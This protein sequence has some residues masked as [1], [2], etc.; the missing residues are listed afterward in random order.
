MHCK[1]C[2]KEMADNALFCKYCGCKVS[3]SLKVTLEPQEQNNVI[4]TDIAGIT[5]G[6]VSNASTISGEVKF[7]AERGH[8]FAAERVNHLHD[9]LMGKDALLVGDDNI[10]NGAD[11]MVNGTAIQSKYCS[12]GSKCIQE[13]FEDGKFRYLNPNGKPMQIEV[14]SDKY[15]DAV[16]AMQDRIRKGE[17]PGVRDPGDAKKYVKKGFLTYEQAKNV[18]RFGTIESIT[19]DAVNGAI[20]GT[21][22]FGITAAITFAVSIWN[23]DDF[24]TAL[25]NALISGLKVGGI[26]FATAV[27]A[28]QMTKAGAYSLV[29]GASGKIVQMIGPKGAALLVNA[30]RSG[31]NIYGAAA[32]KSAQKLLG[33]NIITA[34]VSIV[35]LSSIDIVNI[36]QGRISGAQFFKNLVN[37]TASVGGATAGWAGGAAAGAAVGSVFGPVGTTVGGCIGGVAGAFGVGAAANALSS[38]VTD[39]LIEDDPKKMIR[40]IESEFKEIAQNYMLNRDEADSIASSLSR[41]IDSSMLK[42]MYAS[43]SQYQF[44]R[45]LIEPKAEAIAKSRKHIKLPSQEQ[46]ANGLKKVLEHVEE[47]TMEES[48]E[49]H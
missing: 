21:T 1:G 27:L 37:T 5:Y 29:A 13:C 30:F 24:E 35:V 15:D 16:K 28:G 38:S 40:I 33:S 17:V 6:N 8:G 42:D 44:A 4:N 18:A 7:G 9:K 25:S 41:E 14:P 34:G 10:K 48:Y 32:M 47:Q 12:S 39:E 26:S 43:D 20:I 11:R 19:Y 36:F 2:G 49:M 31:K 23:G 45:N 22:T 3:D 46:I